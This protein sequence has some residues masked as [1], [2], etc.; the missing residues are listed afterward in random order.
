[1]KKAIGYSLLALPFAAMTFFM[2]D[3]GGLNC[4]LVVWGFTLS[5]IGLIALGAWCLDR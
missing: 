2:W 1:M 3:T 5:V 4:V